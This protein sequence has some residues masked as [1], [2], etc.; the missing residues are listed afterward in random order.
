M[1]RLLIVSGGV[2]L[3]FL[4][5]ALGIYVYRFFDTD[6]QMTR[7]QVKM[8]FGEYGLKQ[9][10]KIVKYGVR[11]EGLLQVGDPAP[12]IHLTRLNGEQAPISEFYQE[13]PLVLTFGSYT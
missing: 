9:Y 6:G 7:A 5:A 8:I 1:K 10:D 2:V 11:S 4:G 13:L 12:S 3:L